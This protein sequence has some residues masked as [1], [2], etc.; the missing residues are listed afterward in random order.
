MESASAGV[1]F[2]E[3]GQGRGYRRQTIILHK[4]TGESST[5]YTRLSQK[6][7]LCFYEKNGTM[8]N[9]W[10]IGWGCYPARSARKYE[11]DN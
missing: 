4:K 11:E 9:G 2:R 6:K 5:F 1:G 10:R 7:L 3:P 8:G